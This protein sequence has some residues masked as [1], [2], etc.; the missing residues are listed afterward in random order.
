MSDE[1]SHSLQTAQITHRIIQTNGI[2]MHIAETG[3]GRPVVLLHG[4][5]ELWYSWRHQLGV[6]G[7]AGYH[8][9]A[10]DLRGYG[11]TTISNAIGD[12]SMRN[13]VG[14]VIGLLDAL[15]EE[16]AVIIGHDWG[17]N[18]AWSCAQLHPERISAAVALSIPY[19][20]RPPMPLTQLMQ[21]SNTFNW[22]LYF[23][24][25]GV[26]EAELEADVHRSLRLIF[27]ALSGDAPHELA[28]RLLTALPKDSKLLDP[29]PEPGMLS[30]WLREEDLDY[31]VREFKRT[32]FTGA[33]N[34]YRNVDHDWEELAHLDNTKVGQPA[35]FIGGELDTATRL[36][37]Q[38]LES[39][40]SYVPNL[41]DI[42]IIPGSGHWIQQEYP[43][44]VNEKLI[45]FLKMVSP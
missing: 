14:D 6:L 15:G 12:Y 29:I 3:N 23:Q 22:L 38:R 17:A 4:F 41:Q 32:G 31:Y 28:P 36:A 18:I 1:Q 37:S 19:S 34:R 25:P 7:S 35:L 33:L 45:A 16:T 27:Y 30:G 10:P 20:P 13:M 44:E 39:M 21:K 26:A 9:I 43:Q 2:N 5:P 40:K 11:Q 8:A 42:V 24:N